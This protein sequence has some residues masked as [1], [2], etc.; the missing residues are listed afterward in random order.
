MSLPT[1]QARHRHTSKQRLGCYSLPLRFCLIFVEIELWRSTA[2]CFCRRQNRLWRIEGVENIRL[3]TTPGYVSRDATALPSRKTDV[4]NY[5]PVSLAKVISSGNS[6]LKPRDAILAARCSKLKTLSSSVDRT[7]P[8]IGQWQITY[9]QVDEE[10]LGSCWIEHACPALQP[11]AMASTL[12]ISALPAT[13]LWDTLLHSSVSRMSACLRISVLAR[14]LSENKKC[15]PSSH[16][17]HL[18]H[19]AGDEETGKAGCEMLAQKKAQ[20]THSPT[21]YPTQQLNLG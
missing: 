11:L 12:V 4:E 6:Q 21:A 8:P 1:Q 13:L 2:P 7:N 10:E 20:H 19:E 5:S 9:M 14:R 17:S 15:P 16:P 18:S 3:S